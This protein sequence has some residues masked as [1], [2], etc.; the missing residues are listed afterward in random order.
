VSGNPRPA[1]PRLAEPYEVALQEE[2][3]ALAFQRVNDSHRR[4]FF[5]IDFR[6]NPVDELCTSITQAFNF[7]SRG[8]G[9]GNVSGGTGFKHL[10]LKIGR[11]RRSARVRE[12]R[13]Q[14]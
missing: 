6:R 3:A 1:H 7:N 12:C 2:A 14:P 13:D 11:F 10:V 9:G 8:S 5:D 4:V